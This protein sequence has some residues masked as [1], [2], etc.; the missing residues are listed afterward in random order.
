MFHELLT[1]KG[2][3]T[4]EYWDNEYDDTIAQR[5]E[6]QLALYDAD[7]SLGIMR[8][9]IT[10]VLR[11]HFNQFAINLEDSVDDQDQ[12]KAQ[13]EE[14][15][16][17]WWGD[18]ARPS[19]GCSPEMSGSAGPATGGLE[20]Q[21]RAV[22]EEA[23]HERLYRR[24][25]EHAEAYEEW[26]D[27]EEEHDDHDDT[28]AAILTG[29]DYD[30]DNQDAPSP[31]PASSALCCGQKAGEQYKSNRVMRVA[32]ALAAG[33]S[34]VSRSKSHSLKLNPKLVR[35]RSLV[36]PVKARSV[37]LGGVRMARMRSRDGEL[38]TSTAEEFLTTSTF[39]NNVHNNLR[40]KLKNA[41]KGV[42]I[43]SSR[44][45]GHR[46]TSVPDNS[47]TDFNIGADLRTRKPPPLPPP[48]SSVATDQDI[49]V[50]HSP[51]VQEVSRSKQRPAPK[52]QAV[53]TPVTPPMPMMRRK[54]EDEMDDEDLGNYAIAGSAP[55]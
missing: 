44:K 21:L 55:W 27:E 2:L 13:G 32:L 4:Y 10:H 42:A 33:S 53:T 46:R 5:R 51:S 18:S 36:L 25:S 24:R 15:P 45:R 31:S 39:R 35:S 54:K 43:G 38:L 52:H 1:R 23:D 19:P 12:T 3:T 28:M 50:R 41:G 16:N 48:Q 9:W 37:E 11:V 7:L 20:N 47:P 14:S 17:L 29:W 30:P 6:W 40:D 8:M 49:K 22:M 34:E 26:D